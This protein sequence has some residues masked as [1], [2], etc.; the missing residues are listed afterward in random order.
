MASNLD[1]F[2]KLASIDGESKKDG[3]QKEI[4]ISSWSFSANQAVSMGNNSAGTT[5]KVQMSDISVTKPVDI[6]SPK[7]FL[8][9]CSGERIKSALITGQKSTGAGGQ[10]VFYKVEMEDVVLSQVRNDYQ[11]GTETGDL[12]TIIETV[13]MNP[14]KIKVSYWPFD[15]TG[16]PGSEI[17]TGWDL[18]TNK[19]I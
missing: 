14:S 4:D 15:N 2:L 3:H 16:T 7:L 1:L 8:A 11:S 5:G 13:I 12:A 17:K 10:K 18:Q 19:K 9:C 6:A